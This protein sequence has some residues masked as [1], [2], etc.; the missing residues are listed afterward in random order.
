MRT[1]FLER[2]AD[3]WSV[4]NFLLDFKFFKAQTTVN[5]SFFPKA[6]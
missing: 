2:P 5:I 4:L 6:L 1:W 3:A